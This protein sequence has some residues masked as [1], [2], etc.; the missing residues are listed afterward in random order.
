MLVPGH[1]FRVLEECQQ[2]GRIVTVEREVEEDLVDDG[3]GEN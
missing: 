1:R 3:G 2:M